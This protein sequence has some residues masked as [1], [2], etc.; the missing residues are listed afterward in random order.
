MSSSLAYIENK[1][2]W[3]KTGIF[4]TRIR[5]AHLSLLCVVNLSKDKNIKINNKKKREKIHKVMT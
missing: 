3:N 5:V 1:I 4:N 2:K